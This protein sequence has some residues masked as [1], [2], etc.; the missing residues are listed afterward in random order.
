M[1]AVGRGAVGII[2]DGYCRDTG[3][4]TSRRRR[5]ARHR[6]RTIIPGASRSW[7]CRAPSPAAACRCAPAI[8]SAATT[9][10][11]SSCRSRSPDEVATHARA[12]LL[13]DMHARRKH[14]A[15]QGKQL[16]SPVDVEAVLAYYAGV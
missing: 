8:S 2:T 7:R 10:A 12:I 16:D 6:G 14:Y 4:V 11:S 5:S 15:A 9:T 13:A 3:E 1:G